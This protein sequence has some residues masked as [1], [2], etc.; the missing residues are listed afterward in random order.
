MSSEH[1]KAAPRAASANSDIA[2]SVRGVS[3]SYW[4]YS[5]PTDII[6]EFVTGK[7]LRREHWALRDISFEIPRGSVVGV[8]GTNGSGK[9]TLL[10]IVSGLLDATEG[11][12]EVRGRIS[13]ILELGTGFHPEFTGRENII[14]GGMCIGMSR[15]EIEARMPWIIEFSELGHVIDE[16]FRTYSSGMQ[17]RLTFSTAASVDPDIFIVDEALAAGDAFFV[18]KCMKRMREICKSGATVLFVSHSAGQVAQLCDTAVW[19]EKG[20]I[21]E[22][23]P[24]REITRRYDYGIHL[25]RGS[26]KGQMTEFVVPECVGGEPKAGKV[27]VLRR[28]PVHITKVELLG[29]DGQLTRTFQTW[30]P[31]Q[32]EIHYECVGELPDLGIGMVVTIER[33]PDL[34]RVAQFNSMTPSGRAADLPEFQRLNCEVRRTGVISCR[35]AEL[36]LLEGRYVVS[37][38]LQPNIQGFND[39]Y[40]YHERTHHFSVQAAA[41]PSEAVIY[42]L[43]EWKHWGGVGSL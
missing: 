13:A 33:E 10:R 17:A 3:K 26:G 43:I 36:Q 2:I 38:A 5:R 39:Y 20:H 22:I 18:N 14:M 21:R 31:W 6:R 40:E 32:L 1:D 23:G 27:E 34:L 16:P 7:K 9:S 42:P 25:D 28:G 24:A 30:Q 4:R 37:L 11:T 29:K 19:L 8:L 12:V 15:A 35:M 41:L